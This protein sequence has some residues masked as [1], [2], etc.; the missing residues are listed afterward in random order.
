M[1]SAESNLLWLR[2]LLD[3]MAGGGQRLDA[4]R[5]RRFNAAV[6]DRMIRDLDSSRR[7]YEV[8]CRRPATPTSA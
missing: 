8:L 6:I 7:L 5:A 2:D 4:A 3:Q 1:N